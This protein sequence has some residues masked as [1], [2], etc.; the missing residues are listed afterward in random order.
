MNADTAAETR[1]LIGAGFPAPAVEKS[2]ALDSSQVSWWA[3]HMFVT[4]LV[5]QANATL[6][7]AGTPAWRALDD[8][9]P[10]KLLALAVAGEHHVLRIEIGQ[11]AIADAGQQISAAADWSQVARDVH[12]RHEIDELRRAG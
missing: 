2:N 3:T 12:R 7:W 6:P 5:G 11:D 4:A 9:D 1:P 8:A 10:R